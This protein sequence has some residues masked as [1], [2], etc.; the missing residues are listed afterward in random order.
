MG[1]SAHEDRRNVF[2][3]KLFPAHSSP[4]SP[5]S[6]PPPP[7]ATPRDHPCHHSGDPASQKDDPSARECTAV[8]FIRP[9]KSSQR[10]AVAA[11]PR[12]GENFHRRAIGSARA[13][14]PRVYVGGEMI[15]HSDPTQASLPGGFPYVQ[16]I[17]AYNVTD[18]GY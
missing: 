7:L 9:D 1:V 2:S 6:F 13:R 14:Q 18:D 11:N 10:R 17:Y 8:P 15:F 16:C 3:Q 4:E 12:W 5:T